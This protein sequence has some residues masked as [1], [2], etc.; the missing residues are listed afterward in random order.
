MLIDYVTAYTAL[1]VAIVMIKGTKSAVLAAP[2]KI[3]PR[4]WP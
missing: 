2:S 4:S 1:T 3:A